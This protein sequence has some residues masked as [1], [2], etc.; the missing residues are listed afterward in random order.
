MVGRHLAL[1]RSHEGQG[2]LRAMARKLLLTLDE[3]RGDVSRSALRLV[4]SASLDAQ[5]LIDCLWGRDVRGIA[6]REERPMASAQAKLLAAL[7]RE[8]LGWLVDEEVEGVCYY[9]GLSSEEG[10]DW[11]SSP[12]S[13]E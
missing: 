2:S 7:R 5:S 10:A 11:E 1:A 6:G 4:R 12:A 8:G 3:A 9:A 13:G